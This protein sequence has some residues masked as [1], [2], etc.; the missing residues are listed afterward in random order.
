MGSEQ[1]HHLRSLIVR[2]ESRRIFCEA[3]RRSVTR[4]IKSSETET[5]AD[6][7]LIQRRENIVHELEKIKELLQLLRGE[8]PLGDEPSN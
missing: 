6:S 5:R 4:A 1:E 8:D 3:Q 2:L 7:A